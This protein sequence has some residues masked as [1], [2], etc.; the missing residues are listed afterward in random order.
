MKA[1]LLIVDDDKNNLEMLESFLAY[2]DYAVDT[3]PDT[4]QAIRML[5]ETDYN[6]VITD[7]NMP[8]IGKRNDI[9]GM[10]L[11]AHIRDN[12]PHIPVLMMTGYATVDSAIEAMRMG[13]LD[14]LIKPVSAEVIQKKIEQIIDSQNNFQP[15]KILD[16]C[17]K[18]KQ[19]IITALQ[20]KATES[21]ETHHIFDEFSDQLD[22]LLKTINNREEILIIQRDAL[23][24]IGSLSQQG[25]SLI[26]DD[27][28]ELTSLLEQ[29]FSKATQR[30]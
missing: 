21:A 5:K 2:L 18:A 28:E 25:L 27:N 20:S 1:H 10:E 12:Y 30:F 6:A 9:G 15:E 16:T 8:G 3:A 17:K 13:A 22:M 14:Y 23:T 7:K 26:G 11:I 24:E 4:D 29:I 19:I